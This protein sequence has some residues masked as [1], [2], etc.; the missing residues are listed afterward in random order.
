M[1]QGG[2]QTHSADSPAR[3]LQMLGPKDVKRKRVQKP[4]ADIPDPWTQ[5]GM[6][7]LDVVGAQQNADWFSQPVK[8]TAEFVP[9]YFKVVK[10]PMDL[11]TVRDRLRSGHYATPTEFQEVCRP[12]SLPRPSR[13]FAL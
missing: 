3:T 11:G 12:A 13:G 6:R 5:K 1:P 4:A 2:E 7:V 8:P 10:K 9:D